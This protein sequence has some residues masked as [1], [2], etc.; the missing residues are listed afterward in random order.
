MCVLVMPDMPFPVTLLALI[1]SWFLAKLATLLI[2]VDFPFSVLWWKSST[3]PG[4]ALDPF[5]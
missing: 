3:L 2:L 1:R 4:T 5:P